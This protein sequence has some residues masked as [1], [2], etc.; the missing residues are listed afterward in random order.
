MMFHGLGQT[1]EPEE[2]KSDFKEKG[3]KGEKRRKKSSKG[4]NAFELILFGLGTSMLMSH[5]VFVE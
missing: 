3:S 5:T 1:N 4:I 2:Q